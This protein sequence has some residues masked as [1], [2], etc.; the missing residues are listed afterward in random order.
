MASER[1]RKVPPLIE[2][3]RA[4]AHQF[5]FFQAVR[6]LE[7]HARE[8]EA[9]DGQARRQPIGHDTA[10]DQEVVRIR[11]QQSLAFPATAIDRLASPP[12]GPETGSK[13]GDQRERPPVMFVNFMGLT[14]PSGVLP[15][16][17]THRLLQEAR[18]GSYALSDFFDLFN[19]RLISLFYRAWLKYR[20]SVSIEHGRRAE[21]STDNDFFTFVLSC[22]VGIG[23]GAQRQRLDFPDDLFHYYSGNF[24]SQLAK[25]ANLKSMLSEFLREPVQLR[26]FQGTWLRLPRAEQSRTPIP[27]ELPSPSGLLGSG[28]VL[29]EK[30]WDLQ[31]KFRL[32]VGPAGYRLFQ[33]LM[34]SGDLLR[35]L[36]QF[37]RSYVGVEFDYDVQVVLR[38]EEVPLCALNDSSRLGWNT[39]VRSQDCSRDVEDGVFSLMEI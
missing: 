13:A 21:D 22:L 4:D 19:H 8:T 1:G 39:W 2:A 28:L 37:I 18:D 9:D 16:H 36:H 25:P 10:P 35:P 26:Q 11:V 5:D 14:G 23:T 34:P 15:R 20:A 27:G 32:R 31:S 7:I 33:R 17:Y 30:V 24:A 29:G 12:A 38:A 3:L 6:L